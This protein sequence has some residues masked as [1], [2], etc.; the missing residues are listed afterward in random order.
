M[1]KWL[2]AAW[3]W[4]VPRKHMTHRLTDLPLHVCRSCVGM[5]LSCQSNWQRGVQVIPPF[6]VIVVLVVSLLHC[7]IGYLRGRSYVLYIV[8]A[9]YWV[10]YWPR[11]A[12]D[13]QNASVEKLWCGSMLPAART[14]PR[15]K[16]DYSRL[17]ESWRRGTRT[18]GNHLLI[19]P[20]RNT[21]A[22]TV[23][24]ASSGGK[25]NGRTSYISPIFMGQFTPIP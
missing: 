21:T 15:V 16:P 12:D 11:W 3:H 8:A 17:L 10:G 24:Q 2:V 23:V 19:L 18:R 25:E 4:A 6:V 9:V 13:I 14:T 1:F 22:Y 7:N 5:D 20:Y